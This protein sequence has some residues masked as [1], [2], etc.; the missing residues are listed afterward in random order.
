MYVLVCVCVCL[1][2]CE[3]EDDPMRPVH[4]PWGNRGTTR[5]PLHFGIHRGEEWSPHKLILAWIRTPFVVYLG[6]HM[7]AVQGIQSASMSAWISCTS[8]FYVSQL[9]SA[10]RKKFCPGT[11]EIAGTQAWKRGIGPKKLLSRKI[12]TKILPTS[13]NLVAM[14]DFL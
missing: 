1:C 12:L 9:R 2:V 3:W 11:T 10:Q 7:G 4:I 6:A 8:N 5:G 14:W 13:K